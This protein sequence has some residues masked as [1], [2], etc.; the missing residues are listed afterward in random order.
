MCIPSDDT[1]WQI[2]RETAP[3]VSDFSFCFR[4]LNDKIDYNIDVVYMTKHSFFVQQL[5]NPILDWSLNEDAYIIV[6]EDDCQIISYGMDY[7]NKDTFICF[8]HHHRSSSFVT[9]GLLK[10]NKYLP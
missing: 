3:I 6:E 2:I 1:T 8:P 9:I 4:R 10:T 5:K 7:K